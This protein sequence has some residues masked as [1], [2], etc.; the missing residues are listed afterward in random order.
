MKGLFAALLVP[1]CILGFNACLTGH[2]HR[3]ANPTIV[4][5]LEASLRDDGTLEL[6][7][8]Y[9]D[10]GKYHLAVTYDVEEINNE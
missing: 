7:A 5:V 4:K 8:R 9:S 2:L 6:L 10:G 1:G 3:T